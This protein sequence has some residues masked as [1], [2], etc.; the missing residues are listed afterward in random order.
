LGNRNHGVPHVLV[1]VLDVSDGVIG[2]PAVVVIVVDRGVINRRVGVVHAI[3]IAAAG[4]ITRD[5][6]VARA[7]WKP[8]Y[9]GGATE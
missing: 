3:E 5:V 1:H 8:P 6:G 9:G 7:Q 4:V 2:I